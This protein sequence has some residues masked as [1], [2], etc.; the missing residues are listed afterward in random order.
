MIF[1]PQLRRLI[2]ENEMLANKTSSQT[3]HISG[4]ERQLQKTSGDQSKD[5][6]IAELQD[7]IE[8]LRQEKELLEET[9]KQLTSR[10][11]NSCLT[12]VL[13]VLGLN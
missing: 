8:K 4:L 1:R 6:V 3:E 12:I 9:N 11:S 10:V 2:D 5:A 13:R 7:K